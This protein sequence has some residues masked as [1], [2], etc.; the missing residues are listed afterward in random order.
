MAKGRTE[1][2]QQRKAEVMRL[3]RQGHTFEAIGDRLGIT[4]QRAHQIYAAALA[5]IPA[6]EVTEYRAE[7]AARLD[8]LLTKAHEVL[9]HLHIHVS[10][11]KVVIDERTGEPVRDDGPT[12]AAI[13][14][15]IDIEARRAKLLGLDTPVKQQIGGDVTVTYAF[16]G[17]DLEGLT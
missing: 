3:R 11:G 14:T 5:E 13:K 4:K 1:D 17:V 12:L 6:Q 9:G 8:E 15:I 10:Q 7:Q 16:E 2:T